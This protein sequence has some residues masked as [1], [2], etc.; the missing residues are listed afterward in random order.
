M[1]ATTFP[2]TVLSAEQRLYRGTAASVT[3]PTEDGEITVL[4]HHAPLVA[5]LHAGELIIRH[6]DG[7]ELLFVGGGVV[8]FTPG[9]ECRV[10]ADAAMRSDTIDEKAAEAARARAQKILE[11]ATSESDVAG[12]QAALLHA[13]AQLRIA[14]RRRRHHR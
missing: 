3:I 10:L 11:S 12:A 6:A 1:S 4:P 9:N 13:L 2:L 5:N 8:E 14:E 7:E